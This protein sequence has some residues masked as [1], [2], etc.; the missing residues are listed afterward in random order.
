MAMK[1]KSGK[2]AARK[3][4]AGGSYV[5]QS[6]S[7]GFSRRVVMRTVQEPNVVSDYPVN[8]DLV[9]AFKTAL[10]KAA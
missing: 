2:K 1:K 7:G 3:A 6:A 10:R 5:T 4:S 9:R 8:H